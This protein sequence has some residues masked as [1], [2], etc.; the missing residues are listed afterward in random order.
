MAFD[1]FFTEVKNDLV[2]SNLSYKIPLFLKEFLGTFLI[3]LL[4]LKTIHFRGQ[5]LNFI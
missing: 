3:L 2:T 4:A 5:N 1:Y